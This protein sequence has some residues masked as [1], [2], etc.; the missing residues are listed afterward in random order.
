MVKHRIVAEGI[1][2]EI[3]SGRLAV[4]E[5]IASVAEL[6]TEYGVSVG[7]ADKAIVNLAAM[8]YVERTQGRGT[9]VREQGAVGRSDRVADSVALISSRDY[10]D[11]V[12]F[13]W[14]FIHSVTDEA[15]KNGYHLVLC[16]LSDGEDYSAPLIMRNEHALG[17]LVFDDLTEHQA[18]VLL[19]HKLPHLFIGNHRRTFG[20]PSIRYDMVDAGYQ[21]TRELLALDRGPVW[22]V[23]DP[24]VL[25]YYGQELLEGY[26][27]ALLERTNSNYSYLKPPRRYRNR[28]RTGW[29]LWGCWG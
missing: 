8:G 2:A 3:T 29:R 6:C 26:Q 7:T 19:A 10:S 20:H 11:E 12:H 4:G 28:R 21:M 16:G 5:R 23:I 25:T 9:F 22:L 18:R 14:K 13:N 15:E 27:R 1:L 17:S 24:T